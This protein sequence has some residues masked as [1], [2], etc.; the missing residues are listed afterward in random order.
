MTYT[1]L[2]HKTETDTEEYRKTHFSKL[3]KFYVSTCNVEIVVNS[4]NIGR[5]A[6]PRANS[7]QGH[8]VR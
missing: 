8:F 6:S 2:T 1:I 5:R 4:I 7:G 3:L